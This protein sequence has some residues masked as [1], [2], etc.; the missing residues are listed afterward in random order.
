MIDPNE[1]MRGVRSVRQVE[2]EYRAALEPNGIT[3]ATLTGK[4]KKSDTEATITAFKNGEIDVLISTTVVEVGINVPNATGIIITNAERFGLASLHQLRG[5]VGRGN[6]QS[7]CVLDSKAETPDA[8]ERLNAMCST[9]SG[10]EI[11][12]AD[13]R[14]RGAGDFIGTRQSGFDNKYMA[15]MLAYPEEYEQA[16][17][18]AKQIL[19]MGTACPL[20][21]KVIN[22]AGKTNGFRRGMEGGTCIMQNHMV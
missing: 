1:D 20:L 16:K 8:L 10:F 11:A 12:Q 18:A 14:I 6:R 17:E 4:D 13:L 5:R 7:Y 19:D 15:L 21:E 3:I 9:N 2:A 22:S